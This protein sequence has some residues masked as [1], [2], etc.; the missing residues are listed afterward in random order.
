MR[1]PRPSPNELGLVDVEADRTVAGAR[2]RWIERAQLAAA[3]VGVQIAAGERP[4][5]GTADD[6]AARDRAVA[7]A[8]AV[9]EHRGSVVGGR[10]A[11]LEV[12]GALED[13]PAEVRPAEV[14][15]ADVV[16][17][18]P[19]CPGRHR[20][21]RCRRRGCRTRTG[22]GC[23]GRARRSRPGPRARRTGSNRGPSNRP[24]CAG[25]CA[26]ACP[27]GPRGPERCRPGRPQRRRRRCRGRGSRRGRTAAGPRCGSGTAGAAPRSPCGA[28]RRR[29]GW[30]PCGFGDT[31][32]PR[33]CRPC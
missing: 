3:E 16:D 31:R 1:P 27:A 28:S 20:R 32:P 33:C 29:R 4:Q 5:R 11:A 13:V 30:R 14:A 2:V 24:S 10:P 26:A 7:A 22:T 18:L 15:P 12:V 9:L 8:G 6:V 21:C 19:R 23:A 25:R 17:L